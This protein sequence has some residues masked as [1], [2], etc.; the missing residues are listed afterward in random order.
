MD[1]QKSPKSVGST[2]VL[3]EIKSHS[4][5]SVYTGTRSKMSNSR[6]E[7]QRGPKRKER[8]VRRA[9]EYYKKLG[10]EWK[11]KEQLK[12]Q[13]EEFALPG[14]KRSAASSMHSMILEEKLLE[15]VPEVDEKRKWRWSIWC[16][17]C[18]SELP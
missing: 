14:V 12:Q 5:D 16:A 3:D 2:R 11:D 17:W 13:A 4:G 1:E 15:Q 8:K 9:Q 6:P 7:C 10:L 18:F